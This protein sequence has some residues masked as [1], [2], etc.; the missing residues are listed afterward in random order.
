MSRPGPGS[1]RQMRTLTEDHVPAAGEPLAVKV[2]GLTDPH[3]AAE[4]AAAGARAI[5]LV[6]AA[7]SSRHV[8]PAQAARVAGALP[9]GVARVGVFVDPEP[10]PVAEAV[11][12]AGL[13]H[14][15]V[16]GTADVA[17]LR[18]AG[19][20][21]P[22]VE[23]VR[24]DGPAALDRARASAADAVLLDASVAGAH[25]GTGTRFDWAL[26]E[27]APLGRAFW[28]AGGLTH[29]NVAEAIVRLHPRVVDVSSGVERSPGRKDP[30]RVARFIAAVA[31]AARGRREAA[32]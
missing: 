28:L 25:G 13:T 15:Q 16:H 9:D 1:I 11:R 20:D 29:A 18:A 21:L 30:E 19:L 5:G 2:C 24:V 10:G 12:A 32:A 14:V 31:G 27:G 3:E 4:C 17:L 6:F 26:V 23:G 8:T 7:R 22:I